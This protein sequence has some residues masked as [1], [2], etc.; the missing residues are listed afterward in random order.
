M[1]LAVGASAGSLAAPGAGAAEG[2]SAWLSLNSSSGST[3]CESGEAFGGD[4]AGE[5]ARALGGI[6]LWSAAEAAAA[7]ACERLSSPCSDLPGMMLGENVRELD[8]N[9]GSLLSQGSVIPWY[10]IMKM[11]KLCLG[12]L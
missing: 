12:G 8:C 10:P 5:E 3:R 11:E 6:G 9:Q 7:S 4:P 1:A 2:F